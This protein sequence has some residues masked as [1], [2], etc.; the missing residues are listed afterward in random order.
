[1]A[2]WASEV[3][4]KDSQTETGSTVLSSGETKFFPWTDTGFLVPCLHCFTEYLER[5]RESVSLAP[6]SLLKADSKKTPLLAP[7][8]LDPACACSRETGFFLQFCYFASQ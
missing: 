1:M 7:F 6:L 2:E 4:E 3:A 8:L 5:H